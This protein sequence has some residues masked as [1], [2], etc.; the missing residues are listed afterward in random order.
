MISR[1]SYTFVHSPVDTKCNPYSWLIKIIKLTDV[2]LGALYFML[3]DNGTE[4]S[5]A[6][7]NFETAAYMLVCSFVIF[8]EIVGP[9]SNSHKIDRK[10]ALG[11]T[12]PRLNCL[13]WFKCEPVAVKP[14]VTTPTQRRRQ[15]WSSIRRLE[16]R[17]RSSG[18]SASL[19]I[20]LLSVS[21][22]YRN[23]ISKSLETV[24][25]SVKSIMQLK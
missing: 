10:W 6:L 18:D 2:D 5:Q 3:F 14:I 17:E 21:E 11:E 1:I 12:Y 19:A 8:S 9:K 4:M 23:F 22:R 25:S 16:W 20:T 24:K 13:E 15:I 7:K